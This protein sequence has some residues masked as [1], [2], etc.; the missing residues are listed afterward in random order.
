MPC[1]PAPVE[2]AGGPVESVPTLISYS[3]ACWRRG[4]R[5]G[6]RDASDLGARWRPV[7]PSRDVRGSLARQD[8]PRGL[9]RRAEDE[10][11]DLPVAGVAVESIERTRQYQVRRCRASSSASRR[12]D[13]VCRGHGDPVGPFFMPG[14]AREV[15]GAR[16]LDFVGLR[17]DDGRPVQNDVLGPPRCCA[18]RYELGRQA[19]ATSKRA[20]RARGVPMS[21]H[22]RG[23]RRPASTSRLPEGMGGDHGGRV[24]R[25]FGSRGV[26]SLSASTVT[27]YATRAGRRAA[28]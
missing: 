11:V 7:R 19:P 13:V 15:L 20:Q 9:P 28:K 8:R 22:S 3:V 27:V 10:R 12:R 24:G 25:T 2:R 5:E 6:R 14:G 16:H 21:G 4:P 26:K 1:D 18:A 23:R 17:P